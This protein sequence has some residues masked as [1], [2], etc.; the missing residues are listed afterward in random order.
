MPSTQTQLSY[1]A[2]GRAFAVSTS[3]QVGSCSEGSIQNRATLGYVWLGQSPSSFGPPCWE[4]F[5]WPAPTNADLAVKFTL[6]DGRNRADREYAALAAL[7]QVDLHLAPAPVWLELKRYKNPVVVQEWLEGKVLTTPPQTDL[8][9]ECFL[10]HYTAIHSVTPSTI[11]SPLTAAIYNA[12]S[13]Q[14][15]KRLVYDQAS[16]IPQNAQPKPL[17]ALLKR[18]EAFS[19]QRPFESTQTLCHVDANVSNFILR[20]D[21]LYLVDWEGSGWG[22]PTFEITS[23]ARG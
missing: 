8:E 9:W 2:S 4:H 10:R 1:R 21:R 16:F 20:A 3:T 22:N 13:I 17:Q 12:D 18:F 15:G 7:K 6:R 23:S 11:C 14:G 5:S 19:V